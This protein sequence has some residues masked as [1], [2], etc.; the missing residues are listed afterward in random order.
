MSEDKKYLIQF[1]ARTPAGRQMMNHRR[2]TAKSP[3][4]A[5]SMFYA[6]RVKN[7]GVVYVWECVRDNSRG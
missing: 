7:E 5:L 2:M 3:E 1:R 6:Q 4:E